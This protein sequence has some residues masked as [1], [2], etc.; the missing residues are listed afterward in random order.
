MTL[1]I[2]PIV[3]GQTEQR[4]LERLLQRIWRELHSQSERLQVLEPFRAHR[5]RLVQEN[6]QGLVACVLKAFEKLK[7]KSSALIDENV[8]ARS[9]V[10]IL[11]D[12][13]DACPATLGPRLLEQA[14][15]TLPTSASVTCVLA[16]RMLENWI[17]AGASTLGGVNGLPAELLPRDLFEDRNGAG[18]LNE[19]LKRVHPTRKYKKTIDAE[20]FVR[21]MDLLECR[22]NSPSFDKLCRELAA[23]STRP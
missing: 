19:Q 2:Q 9:L 5:D 22:K 11:L 13:E 18:W 1:H 17:F 4:C 23:V 20:V 21:H 8:A 6:G 7:V 14:K 12:A 16:N 15:S 10:L 3:E